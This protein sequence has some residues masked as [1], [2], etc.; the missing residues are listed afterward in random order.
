LTEEPFTNDLNKCFAQELLPFSDIENSWA[1][2]YIMY[3]YKTGVI[4]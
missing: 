3:L 1:K 2:C 4:D